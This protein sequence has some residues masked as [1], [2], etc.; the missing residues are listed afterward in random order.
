M[1]IYKALHLDKTQGAIFG[2]DGNIEKSGGGK[3]NSDTIE[4]NKVK[5]KKEK[6]L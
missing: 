4:I 1:S 2:L 5:K 3:K 6:I